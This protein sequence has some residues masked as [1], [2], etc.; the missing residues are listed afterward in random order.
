MSSMDNHQEPAND[1]KGSFEKEDKTE[2]LASNVRNDDELAHHGNPTGTSPTSTPTRNNIASASWYK[3]LR[4][5]KPILKREKM[6]QAASRD[7]FLNQ[8]ASGSSTRRRST[9]EDTK[10][11][12]DLSRRG[13][14]SPQDKRSPTSLDDASSNRGP[15]R[16]STL[17]NTKY[18]EAASRCATESAD[19]SLT[20]TT[21]ASSSSSLEHSVGRELSARRASELVIDASVTD[22]VSN[23]DVPGAFAIDEYDVETSRQMTA[24]PT[25]SQAA[26]G[27]ESRDLEA[28]RLEGDSDIPGDHSNFF[29]AEAQAVNDFA[30]AEVHEPKGYNPRLYR[31]LFVVGIFIAT[32]VLVTVLTVALQ[33]KP[34]ANTSTSPPPFSAANPP[35]PNATLPPSPSPSPRLTPKQIAC[36]FIGIPQLVPCL[37]VIN[38]SFVNGFATGMTIPSEIGLLT[39][40]GTLDVSSSDLKGSI[41]ESIGRLTNLHA[42]NFSNN[43]LTGS[44]PRSIG[45][46]PYLHSLTFG[47]NK[48][49]GTI[50]ASVGH[51]KSL[52]ALSLKGIPDLTGSIPSSIENLTLLTSLYL[53]E[54][55]LRGTIPSS[56]GKLA[57]LTDICLAR[58][59]LTGSI[60]SSF[61]DLTMLSSLHLGRNFLTGSIPSSFEDLTMLSRFII[62]WNTLTGTFPAFIGNW[63]MLQELHLSNNTFTGSIPALIRNL[64]LLTSLSLE[65]NRMTGSIPS[66]ICSLAEKLSVD[67]DK[68]ECSCCTVV[69]D[70]RCAIPSQMPTFP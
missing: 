41:P 4:D 15:L 64:T 59:L 50:P 63:T 8:I 34:A 70:N 51:L 2:Q 60:P 48:I 16:K 30:I 61:G 35:M 45:N 47:P 19:S 31:L 38:V 13:K 67:C 52:M 49:N 1:G 39:N 24:I 10:F 66:S 26:D 33:A 27:D 11:R 69:R 58:N 56:I 44:I 68:V 40:L 57:L 6:K 55:R 62:K 65:D 29:V 54:T 53:G 46:F 9:L 18:R 42:L 14:E 22:N 28:S 36:N 5:G 43:E 21:Q 7:V 25:G 20:S 37:Q 3:D 23:Y 32:A 17:E 12:H